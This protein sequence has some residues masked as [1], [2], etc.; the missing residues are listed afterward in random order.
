[1]SNKKG[2]Y[3]PMKSSVRYHLFRIKKGHKFF[4][5]QNA[6]NYNSLSDKFLLYHQIISKLKCSKIVSP[7]FLLFK[8]IGKFPSRCIQQIILFKK[9]LSTYMNVFI[10]LNCILQNP[11]KGGRHCLSSQV[12]VM[13]V[14]NCLLNGELVIKLSQGC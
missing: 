5:H 7:V 11:V 14:L 3:I 9:K 10:K 2:E 4:F 8:E 13:Q 12:S 6:S 1:M